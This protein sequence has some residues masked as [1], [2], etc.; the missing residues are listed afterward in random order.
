ML[1]RYFSDFYNLLYF[2]CVKMKNQRLE[3]KFFIWQKFISIT[4]QAEMKLTKHTRKS[5][6]TSYLLLIYP[7]YVQSV[8]TNISIL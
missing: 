1:D 7:F 2:D 5:T 3:V 6:F 8:V 4:I